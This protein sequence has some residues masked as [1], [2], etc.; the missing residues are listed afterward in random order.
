MGEKAGSGEDVSNLA[1]VSIGRRGTPSDIFPVRNLSLDVLVK[2]LLSIPAIKGWKI[3]GR[4]KGPHYVYYT[5]RAYK[6]LR[7]H[8]QDPVVRKEALTLLSLALGRTC[9]HTVFLSQ[10]PINPIQPE[11]PT[12]SGFL[13]GKVSRGGTN[14]T[15]NLNRTF[16]P[17]MSYVSVM[18]MKPGTAP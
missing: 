11:V 14:L 13:L 8:P 5:V 9:T 10:R 17:E 7:D 16:W 12:G 3:E 4:K 15:S 18:K 1:D 6:M 2:V